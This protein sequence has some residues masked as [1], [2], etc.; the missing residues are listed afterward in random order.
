MPR[1]RY[2]DAQKKA[3]KLISG[4]ALRIM[5]FGG[6]RS[7]KSFVLC[8]ALLIRALKAPGSRH[9]I[10]R[11]HFNTVRSSIGMDT[12]PKVI[13][14]RFPDLAVQFNKT[15]NVFKLENGSEIWLIG[16]D[17]DTRAEKILGK[18]FCTIYFNEC[19]ELDYRS[20]QT[21]LTRLAQKSP[22]LRNKALFDCN[23]PGKSHWT[24]RLFIE[25]LN[26]VDR[27]PLSDPASYDAMRINPVD[28]AG[29][30]PEDY[31]KFT[32][33][34]LPEREKKRFL[35]GLFLDENPDALW[36]QELIDETR[37]IRAP[38]LLRIVIGVDPAVS[39]KDNSDRTGIVA[40]A[41]GE[42]GEYYILADRSCRKPVLRW[43]EEVINLYHELAADRVVGEV[44]NGGD[45]VEA[46]L[47]KIDPDLSFRA[48]SALRG[49]IVRAE[50][51]AAMYEKKIVHHV[52]I[53]P[54]LEEE[55]TGFSPL[56]ATHSPDRLD[57]LV[58]ALTELS[59]DGC[60][61]VL[62]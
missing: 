10:I 60:R 45:L 25:K 26:P 41:L 43:G 14:T 2:T 21:A 62:A 6:S 4:K 19:S 51:I 31:I 3:L 40:A 42:D 16:L 30:L 5:L 17:D 13:S 61:F 36:H 39:S 57:A 52:G 27:T 33:A 48:V 37:V 58:W 46:M 47:R 54:D 24:Y 1:F 50:P 34:N 11:R 53:F 49:K 12:M 56:S 8:A 23:P 32:L 59:R 38:E 55:M 29:N 28:N 15:D 44:N 35:E 20:V 9:A 7:G 22:P 18:E